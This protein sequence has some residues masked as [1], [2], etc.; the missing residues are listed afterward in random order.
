M[1]PAAG[2]LNP[3][4]G[5]KLAGALAAASGAGMLSIELGAA[6][7][8]GATFGTSLPVWAAVLGVTMLALAAG[9]FAG[10]GWVDRRPAAR[11]LAWMF[12]GAA[13]LALA[14]P[15]IG[16]AATR[17]FAGW[18][19]QA[20]ATAASLLLLGPALTLLGMTTP[21][22]V[23]LSAARVEES[24]S[25]AGVVYA[26]T[27]AGGVLMSAACSLWLFPDLGLRWTG[28]LTAIL[29]CGGVLGGLRQKRLPLLAQTPMIGS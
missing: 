21:A 8:L 3:P 10:G 29:L 2:E 13:A 25:A 28:L 9:Y 11:G 16:P 26:M 6:K 22:L 5:R 23:R 1:G 20:G 12:G 4:L 7:V 15:W 19:V 14:L 27:T 18:G 24:G 17:A